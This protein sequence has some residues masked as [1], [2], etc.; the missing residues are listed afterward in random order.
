MEL[1]ELYVNEVGRHLPE[2][3]RADIQKEIRSSIEDTLEDMSRAQGR[4]VDEAMVVEA[5]KNLGS[6][7][8]VAASYLPPQYL[9]GP[10][11]FPH[12]M[13]TLKVFIPIILILTALGMGVSLGAASPAAADMVQALIQAFG[14]LINAA[15]SVVGT[16][17][18]IFALIQWLNPDIRLQKKE[19]DPRKMKAEPDP[20]RVKVA[21]PIGEIIFTV[22]ALVVFNLYP[23]WIGP[24]SYHN[25][26]W[27]TAP[28]LTAAFFQYLPWLN[29]VWALQIGMDAFLLSQGR[30]TAVTRWIA[31]AVSVFTI[32]IGVRMLAGPA[33]VALDPEALSKLGWGFSSRD[34]FR[35]ASEGLATGIRILIGI[36]V[37]LEVVDIVKHLYKLL[38]HGQLPEPA[39]IK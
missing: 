18:I 37:A 21:E 1:I 34:A 14:R 29:V 39:A 4:P 32:G 30:W 23:Q 20:E 15:I 28:V 25:G 9:I 3:M 31:I 35:T 36:V 24:A 27:V 17:V 16:V 38:L 2:K 11:L 10:E 7:E 26:Q 33:I 19:W 22:I 8:K 6:P 5:L 13:N 12:F